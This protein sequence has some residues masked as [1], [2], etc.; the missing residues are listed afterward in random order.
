MMLH[1]P[2]A[3]TAGSLKES[4]TRF[5]SSNANQ[6]CDRLKELPQEKQTGNISDKIDDEIAVIVDKLL[7]DKCFFLNSTYF[8]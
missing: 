3:S 1:K 2:P 5:L 7:E 8:Y 6:I 4:K